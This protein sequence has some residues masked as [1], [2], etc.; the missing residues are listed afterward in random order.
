MTAHEHEHD[1]EHDRGAAGRAGWVAVLEVDHDLAGRLPGAIVAAAAPFAVARAEWLGP[2]H[3]RPV[4]PA[5][6][7]RLGHLGYLVLDGFLA[8]QVQVLQRPATELLGRGDLLI[9]WE[10]DRTE[11]F[12]AGSR[13]EVPATTLAMCAWMSVKVV[14]PARP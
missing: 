12:A 11:P 7:D 6:E 9:P 1:H 5:E 13:W 3:W 10:P 8:R 2:G 4:P 14:D